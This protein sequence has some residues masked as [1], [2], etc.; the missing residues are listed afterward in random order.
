[1]DAAGPPTIFPGVP[2]SCLKE[3]NCSSRPTKIASSSARAENQRKNEEKKDKIGTFQVFKKE[4]GK[5]LNTAMY[6]MKGTT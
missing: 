3:T 1:M 4:V 2:N 6:F 5:C